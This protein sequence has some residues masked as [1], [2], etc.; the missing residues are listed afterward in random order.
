MPN[1]CNGSKQNLSLVSS[2][3]F[4]PTESN[5]FLTTGVFFRAK[6]VFLVAQFVGNVLQKKKLQKDLKLENPLK[7]FIAI[8]FAEFLLFFNNNKILQNS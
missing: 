5:F 2:F 6:F 7:G 1:F 8:K 3:F 4:K